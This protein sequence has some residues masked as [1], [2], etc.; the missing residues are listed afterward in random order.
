MPLK[1]SQADTC[2]ASST[3]FHVFENPWFGNLNSEVL[4]RPTNLI[5]IHYNEIHKTERWSILASIN[6]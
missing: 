4:A 3:N 5:N 2:A 1:D 6:S